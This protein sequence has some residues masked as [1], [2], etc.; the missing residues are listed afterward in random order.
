MKHQGRILWAAAMTAATVTT[1]SG[2]TLAVSRQPAA[3]PD[4]PPAVTETV[5]A[6][7][8]EPVPVEPLLVVLLDETKAQGAI[9]IT[10]E[11]DETA[12]QAEKNALGEY[13]VE[14]EPGQ[15]YTVTTD[16]G[17]ETAFYLEDNA[18]VS[19]VTGNGWTDGEQLH[20]D[21]ETRCTL[22]ILRAGGAECLYTLTG[23]GIAEQRALY[24]SEGGSQA[25]A[26]FAGLEPGTYTLSG[27][28][29]LLRTV[30]LTAEQAE[31]VL[32]LD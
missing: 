25:Q 13:L 19:N 28:D 16:G 30:S 17:L 23:Q 12:A 26:I 31:V 1:I 10:G 11:G 8:T 4:L 21:T 2:Y 24:T 14:L 5:Q 22:R 6:D 27:T 32:G 9:T 20:L 3:L 29:G 15:R 18:A 7:M